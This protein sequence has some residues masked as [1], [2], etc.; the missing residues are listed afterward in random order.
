[1]GGAAWRRLGPDLRDYV[2]CEDASGHGLGRAP[3][4]RPL[5]DAISWDSLLEISSLRLTKCFERQK[6]PGA[7]ALFS[8]QVH[9]VDMHPLDVQSEKPLCGT[10]DRL[11]GVSKCFGER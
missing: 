9:A 11:Y 8:Q 6:K 7:N 5:P 3:G 4:C 1:M 10:D 2:A